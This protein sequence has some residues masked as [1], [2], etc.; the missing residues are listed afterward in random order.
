M[1]AVWLEYRLDWV[2]LVLLGV[3][4]LGATHL[5]LRRTHRFGAPASTWRLLGF[6]LFA[7]FLLA[8]WAA[9]AGRQRLRSLLQGM[10]PT[11]AVEMERRGHSQLRLDTPPDDSLYLEL[12]NAEKLWLDANQAVSDIY[13]FRVLANGMV[14]RMVDSE[15][16]HDRDGR[17]AGEHEARAAL[18]S[19]Y[20]D[21]DDDMRQAFLGD[22][23]FNRMPTTNEWGTWVSAYVPLRDATGRV[24]GV[25]GVDYDAHEWQ[26]TIAQI[27]VATLAL[28]A[29]V[30]SVVLVSLLLVTLAHAEVKVRAQAEEQLRESEAR[31]RTLADGAPLMIWMEDA[32][33]G[34]EYTNAAWQQYRGG[35]AAGAPTDPVDAI[36]PEDRPAFLAGRQAPTAGIATME[37]RLRRHDG[38]YRWIQETRAV[39]HGL[40]EVVTGFV[41]I[42]SDVTDRRLAASEL[43]RARDAAL[44][45]A[46][47][48]SEFLANMSHEIRT[49]M[50]GVLGMLELLL[51][52]ELSGEQRDRAETAK[53]SAEALLTVIN[54]V[55][56]FSKI[57][58]GRLD[59]EAIDFDLRNTLDDVTGLLGD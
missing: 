16:D 12:I 18:G 25:L 57:E 38:E 9:D 10:A 13:T 33:G 35:D 29:L 39:R 52:T 45:S 55:L 40:D 46:R 32:T 44:E 21:V 50:N 26:G 23:T 17:Y 15:T 54:D 24:E 30:G 27:R 7:A 22:T 20:D 48:K 51:D 34:L 2:V 36:H 37:Y 53:R 19:A 1:L 47:M 4:G 5:F 43:A 14:V 31:F 11:Y 58:A 41:G 42:G 8:D 3:A 56:D 59:I 49:P 28:V 6:F